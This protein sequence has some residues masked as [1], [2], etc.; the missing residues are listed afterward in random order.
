[1]TGLL[2]FLPELEELAVLPAPPGFRRPLAHHV[3]VLARLDHLTGDLGTKDHVV[4]QAARL[5]VVVHEVVAAGHALQKVLVADPALPGQAFGQFQRVLS[6]LPVVFGFPLFVRLS[7]LAHG[8]L[9]RHFSRAFAFFS[10]NSS[11]PS[12]SASEMVFDRRN[13][14]GGLPQ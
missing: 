6:R 3:L 13:S 12:V 9:S 2:F 7:L 10:N 14:S 11:Q 4:A 1:T 8:L 5:A